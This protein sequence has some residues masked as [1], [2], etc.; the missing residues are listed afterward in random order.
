MVMRSKMPNL[1]YVGKILNLNPIPEADRLMQATVSCK[2]GGTWKG[3]VGKD[4]FLEGEL[5]LVFLQDALLPP[6]PEY[7]FMEKYNYRVKMQRLRGCPSE[8][9]IVP[10]PKEISN[11][12]EGDNVTDILGVTKYE[13][14]SKF[15]QSAD[16]LGEFPSFIPITDEPN[17]QRSKHLTDALFGLKY[18]SSIKYDGSSGTIYLKE[19]GHFG[20][21]SRNKEYK[22]NK[23]L[24]LWKLVE[25]Y[26]LDKKLP[27]NIAIQFEMLGP[28][29]Q[30]NVLNLK[31]YDLRVFNVYSIKHYEY[32]DIV[33]ALDFCKGLG[34]PFVEIVKYDEI[35]GITNPDD[36][37]TMAQ[38]VY[39]E[40]GN[41]VEGIVI[42]PMLERRVTSGQSVGERL[43]FK[44]LNLDYKNH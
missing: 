40:T 28:K 7:A 21:C 3:V 38:Q 27:K 20:V 39:P 44:V 18:Y 29:I 34:L 24:V 23:D 8:V 25:K 41:P 6:K 4:T 13:K 17:F 36:L 1:A 43:S 16:I 33:D 9:L 42:R 35:F 30:K 10:V 22:F 19:D 14:P 31:D 37:R 12:T 15:L 2:N 5:C 32:I 26:D 11:P